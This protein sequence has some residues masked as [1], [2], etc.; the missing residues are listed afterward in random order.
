MGGTSPRPQNPRF[1]DH[2]SILMAYRHHPDALPSTHHRIHPPPPNREQNPPGDHPLP[3][4]PHRPRDLPPAHQPT[5]NT[6]RR[7]PT[8]PTPPHTDHPHPRR[9]RPPNPPQPHLPTRTRPIP[10]PPPRHPIPT[11]AHPTKPC[12]YLGCSRFDKNRS[13]IEASIWKTLIMVVEKQGSYQ[14]TS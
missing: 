12:E 2:R 5:T 4:T 8:H 13:I 3:K 1:G 14:V 6:Q 7:P 11:L 10:Q 9:H